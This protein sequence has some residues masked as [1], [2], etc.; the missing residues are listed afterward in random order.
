[1]RAG[2]LEQGYA[3]DTPPENR[4]AIVTFAHGRDGDWIARALQDASV[5]ASP[6]ENATKLRVGAALF[7]NAADVDRLLEVTAAWA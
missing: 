6:K 7:N 3:V 1:L 2:L 4:S 5:S